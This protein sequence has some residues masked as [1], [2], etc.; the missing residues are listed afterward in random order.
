ML[1]RYLVMGFNSTIGPM[2]LAYIVRLYAVNGKMDVA[3]NDMAA[4]KIKLW[5]PTKLSIIR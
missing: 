2:V 3:V 4:L 5:R 1:I